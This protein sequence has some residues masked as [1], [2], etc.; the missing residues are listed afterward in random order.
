MVELMVGWRTLN[1]G[2][3]GCAFFDVVRVGI[4][5]QLPTQVPDPPF[6]FFGRGK[7]DARDLDPGRTGIFDR[8]WSLNNITYTHTYK[9]GWT[10]IRS[11]KEEV[12]P[13]DLFEEHF[14]QSAALIKLFRMICSKDLFRRIC[15]KDLLGKCRT[16]KIRY[17]DLPPYL[18]WIFCDWCY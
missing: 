14:V 8:G 2:L 10:C 6:S 4:L 1:K 11:Q 17:A 5:V 18:L 13:K 16:N 9:D 7:G 12:F 15:P 3:V